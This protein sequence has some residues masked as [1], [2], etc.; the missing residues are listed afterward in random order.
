MLNKAV[1]QIQGTKACFVDTPS[2]LIEKIQIDFMNKEG[3]YNAELQLASKIPLIPDTHG[4]F[5]VQS[6]LLREK[7]MLI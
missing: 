5:Y 6:S 1:D 2:V 4:F 7:S 3:S